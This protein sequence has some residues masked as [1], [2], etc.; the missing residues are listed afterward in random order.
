MYIFEFLK[1]AIRNAMV[2]AAET[3]TRLAYLKQPDSEAEADDWS[4]SEEWKQ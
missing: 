1:A 3:R 2:E 4:N